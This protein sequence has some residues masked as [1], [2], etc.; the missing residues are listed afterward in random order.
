MST[1]RGGR[2]AQRLIGQPF[3]DHAQDGAHYHGQQHAG[4]S[5]D[6]GAGQRA[7]LKAAGQ[8]AHGEKTDI[9]PHHNDVS[10][11]KVQH[12]GN[13]VDH[14][15][16]QGNDGVHA[17]QTDAVDE[18]VENTQDQSPLFLLLRRCARKTGQHGENLCGNV[19]RRRFRHACKIRDTGCRGDPGSPFHGFPGKKGSSE[20]QRAT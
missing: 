15:I 10:V 3:D 16:A 14:R 5:R 17:A 6:H 12:F 7:L 8:A 20:N 1:A 11:G 13:T 18:I 2:L 9:C 4:Q 19:C